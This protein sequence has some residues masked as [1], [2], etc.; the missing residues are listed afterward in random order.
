M[1]HRTLVVA[2]ALTGAALTVTSGAHAG[3]VEDLL[4]ATTTDCRVE[5]DG[6]TTSFGVARGRVD[7]GPERP[8][9]HGEI[10]VDLADGHH[11][12]LIP[13]TLL[14]RRDGG[15]VPAHGGANIADVGGRA[16][17]NGPGVPATPRATFQVHVEDRGEGR[18]RED[19]LA[20]RILD[21]GGEELRIDAGFLTGGDIRLVP[22]VPRLPG[23]ATSSDR[24]ACG[25]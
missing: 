20:L 22:V 21:E 3:P 25:S 14:C 10:Q 9:G 16:V 7:P 1:H 8:A 2:A 24:P 11:L 23:C 13:E 5:L 17:S 6:A 18:E 4:I 15:A 19:Y 12:V